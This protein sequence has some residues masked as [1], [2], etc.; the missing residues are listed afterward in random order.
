V[1]KP[2]FFNILP[3][4]TME[5][6]IKGVRLINNLSFTV[7]VIGNEYMVLSNILGTFREGQM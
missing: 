1:A 6:G 3:L 4:P 7:L 2:L 5:R